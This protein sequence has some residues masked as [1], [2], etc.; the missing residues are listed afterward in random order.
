MR[1]VLDLLATII[2]AIGAA[3]AV[4]WLFLAI[5]LIGG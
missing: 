1:L 4:V 3:C 2:G 5:S